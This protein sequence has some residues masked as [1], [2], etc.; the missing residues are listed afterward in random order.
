M[1]T[2]YVYIAEFLNQYY[3]LWLQYKIKNTHSKMPRKWQDD[4]SVNL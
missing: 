4:F 3:N 1:E 2:D